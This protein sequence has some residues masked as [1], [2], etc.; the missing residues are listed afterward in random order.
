M[1]AGEN[2]SAFTLDGL[3]D[4]YQ[5]SGRVANVILE[6]DRCGSFLPALTAPPDHLRISMA[7]SRPNQNAIWSDNG[8]VSFTR[9]FLNHIWEGRTIGY[10][11][12]K[13]YYGLKSATSR[14]Q[15]PEID[16]DGDGVPEHIGARWKH[17]TERYLGP[18]FVTGD[19]T[20][21]IGSVMPTSLI[22][23]ANSSNLWARDILDVDGITNVWC[24]V[25]PPDFDE[26]G[27]LT[28]TNLSYNSA[29]QRWEVEY[30]N[31]NQPGVYQLTFF[32]KDTRGNISH[33]AQSAMESGDIYETDD[34]ADQA[35]PYEMSTFQRHSFH[36]PDDEDWV[37]V[38]LVD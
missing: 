28:E 27:D 29:K 24:V 18:A 21:L 20:P 19:D 1:N 32:A 37:R 9:F 14:F 13:A 33:P 31:F 8:V 15:L 30:T 11:F 4:Q 26:V 5:V 36:S 10:A 35:S 12:R 38:Y 34:T 2:L 3:L 25:T 7:S 17:S 16:D 22:F 6:F 23:G